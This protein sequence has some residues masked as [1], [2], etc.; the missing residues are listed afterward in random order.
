VSDDTFLTEDGDGYIRPVVGRSDPAMFTGAEVV[1]YSGAKFLVLRGA[2]GR[3][4]GQLDV[5]PHYLKTKFDEIDQWCLFT[6][7]PPPS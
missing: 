1:G 7:A 6:V 3:F 5:D 2:S 4:C